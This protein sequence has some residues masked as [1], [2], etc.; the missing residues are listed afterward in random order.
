MIVK[1]VLSVFIFKILLGLNP[2]PKIFLKHEANIVINFNIF[3]IET[4]HF[5]NIA[6]IWLIMV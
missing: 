2:V 6:H 3:K 5:W 1:Y 4:L